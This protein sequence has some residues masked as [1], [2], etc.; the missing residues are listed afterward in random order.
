MALIFEVD[1]QGHPRPKIQCDTCG[2]VIKDHSH[3]VALLDTSSN[4]PGTILEP[5]FR[6]A[7][8]EE[9]AEVTGR[10][11]DTMPIDQFLLYLLNNIQLTPNA[12][13]QA[14]RTMRDATKY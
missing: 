8:C 12:L 5:I 6:C 1:H 7:Q 4:K 11:Q 2:G 10:S 9:K 13:E 3:G 14:G